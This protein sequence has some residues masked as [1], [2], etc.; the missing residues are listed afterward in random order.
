VRPP[1]LKAQYKMTERRRKKE[2]KERK[3]LRKSQ[4]NQ[5]RYANGTANKLK[6]EPRCEMERQEMKTTPNSGIA[7]TNTTSLWSLT[8]FANL[9]K[10]LEE[11]LTWC[12]TTRKENQKKLVP[13]VWGE[14]R[15]QHA[16]RGLAKLGKP[17]NK[18]QE[19]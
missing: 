3:N 10:F 12:R 9:S 11:Y 14:S 2:K 13:R 6:E 5:N 4:N 8:I 1:V 7:E 17:C 15:V 18:S 19:I 16:P